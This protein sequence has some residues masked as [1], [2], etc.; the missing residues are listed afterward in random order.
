LGVGEAIGF[1][2]V[3]RI[4]LIFDDLAVETAVGKAVEREDVEIFAV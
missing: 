2:P 4:N 3:G 1:E